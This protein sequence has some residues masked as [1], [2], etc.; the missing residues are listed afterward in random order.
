[1]FENCVKL[2]GWVILPLKSHCTMY[3]SANCA[4][5]QSTLDDFKTTFENFFKLP[6]FDC[7][8]AICVLLQGQKQLLFPSGCGKARKTSKISL[9]SFPRSHRIDQKRRQT[10]L[11]RFLESYIRNIPRL[12]PEKNISRRILFRNM[13]F[14]G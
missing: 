12:F 14:D 7:D 5:P 10:I 9:E 11:V 3:I 8:R 4:G 1:M 13:P 6:M 2:E